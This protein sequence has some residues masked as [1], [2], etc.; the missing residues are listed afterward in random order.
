MKN[1]TQRLV[2]VTVNGL[3]GSPLVDELVEVMIGL[4]VASSSTLARLGNYYGG[5]PHGIAQWWLLVMITAL[6]EDL[7]SLQ[8]S[9]TPLRL[10]L[11]VV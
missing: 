10:H 2:I 8:T 6:S 11:L 9:S 7:S 1:S 4:P 3:V 5:Q